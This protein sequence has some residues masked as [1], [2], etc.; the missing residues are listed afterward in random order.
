L[1]PEKKKAFGP[2]GAVEKENVFHYAEDGVKRVSTIVDYTYGGGPTGEVEADCNR[3]TRLS[4]FRNIPKG[5]KYRQGRLRIYG[6][7][8][9]WYAERNA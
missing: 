8:D 4:T 7:L 2:S 5:Q 3:K 6:K 9:R 1:K